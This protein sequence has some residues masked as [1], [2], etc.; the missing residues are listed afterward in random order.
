[1]NIIFVFLSFIVGCIVGGVGAYWLINKGHRKNKYDIIKWIV[2]IVSIIMFLISFIDIDN[3][4]VLLT[5]FSSFIFSWILAE[6][7]TDIKGREKEKDLA[8]RSFR[9]SRNLTS[10]LQYSILISDLLNENRE[11]SF[12]DEQEC[13]YHSNLMRIRDLLITFKKDASEIE[14][15]WADVLAEDIRLYEE[16]KTCDYQIINLSL[17]IQDDEIKEEDTE[18]YKAE[19][20][21]KKKIMKIN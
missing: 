5:F 18:K 12:N 9:H 10:K 17:K 8:I 1:M 7:S 19:K 14:N 4:E 6:F 3:T 20:A 11:C 21:K 16:I 15:D 2:V 13:K